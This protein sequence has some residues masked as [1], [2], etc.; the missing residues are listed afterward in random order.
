M[1]SIIRQFKKESELFTHALGLRRGKKT[2]V[3][4]DVGHK[5]FRVARLDKG[6]HIK[7]TLAGKMEEIKDLNSKIHME[8]ADEISMNVSSDLVTVA[9]A[10]IPLMPREE[11]RE[12]LRWELKDKVHIDMQDAKIRFEILAEKHSDDGL[13]RLEIK[14]LLYKEKDI[15]DKVN[16]FKKFGL[17]IH[18][19]FPSSLALARYI[20]YTGLAP[21]NE[22]IG[23]VDIGSV[24]T[25]IGIV[26][27][28]KLFFARDL[29]VGG[30]T[31]TEAMTGVLLSD[32]GRVELSEEEAERIK[33]EQG[34]SG[35]IKIM[36]MMR[37]VLEKLSNEIKRS[38]EYFEHKYSHVNIK[39]II[40]AGNGAKLKGLK[41]F[42]TKET[43]LEVADVL[44]ENACAIGLALLRDSSLNII[45]ETYVQEKKSALKKVSLRMV[46]IV[47]GL[48]FLISYGFLSMR[49]DYLKNEI[50]IVKSHWENMKVLKP[51]KEE[52]IELNSIIT[53]VSTENI[54][55]ANIMKELSHIM[56]S[57][58]TL[59]SLV[60]GKAAPNI[61]ISGIIS[62]SDRLTEVMDD[63]ERSPLFENV[64]LNFSREAGPGLE[65][66]L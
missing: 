49:V 63:I 16:E 35:D 4:L 1:N 10:D 25:V 48:L 13:K 60:T 5:N 47:T 36:S 64:K 30:D 23:I 46:F 61:R 8:P 7:E 38:F 12:A 24:K 56:P 26:E 9:M 53:N 54:Y 27:N 33:C 66:V 42:L 6:G 11:I 22:K 17:N 45:P 37:P 52:I 40:L 28:G 65:G 2:V 19:V 41:D 34:I 31:I 14:T 29:A 39:K 3:G 44:P 21:K 62:E 57:Y 43:G 55:V 18:A 58:V 50:N 32:K 51:I 59:N 20:E 15:E